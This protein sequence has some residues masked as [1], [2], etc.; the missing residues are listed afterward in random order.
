M[1]AP[2]APSGRILRVHAC[3]CV[4]VCVCVY[5]GMW[6]LQDHKCHWREFPSWLSSN[7][8]ARIH[9]DVGSIPGLLGGLR[10]QHCGEL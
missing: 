5:L 6:A 7:E 9:E 10:I 3:V 8:P 1:A 2:L 4:C